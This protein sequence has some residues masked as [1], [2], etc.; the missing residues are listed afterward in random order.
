MQDSLEKF[1]KQRSIAVDA[2]RRAGTNGKRY[3]AQEPDALL[4]IQELTNRVENFGVIVKDYSMG[5]ID[6]P[7]FRNGQE[8]YLCWKLGE[9]EVS[10]WHEIESGFSGRKPV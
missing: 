4:E 6:F 7:S 9:P 10:H 3:A 8:I 2:L 5:L 1:E